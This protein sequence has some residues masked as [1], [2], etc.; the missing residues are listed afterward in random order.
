MDRI[1]NRYAKDYVQ[2]TFIDSL[3]EDGAFC[4]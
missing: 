2:K 4:D 1:N 3:E